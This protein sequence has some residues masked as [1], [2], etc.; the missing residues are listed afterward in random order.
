MKCLPGHST[1]VL[2]LLLLL[3]MLFLV[4]FGIL[5]FRVEFL[6]GVEQLRQELKFIPSI[7][8]LRSRILVREDKNVV[9]GTGYLQANPSSYSL[10]ETMKNEPKLNTLSC[11]VSCVCTCDILGL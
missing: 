10:T 8:T 11:P 5:L 4:G 9:G 6:R 7:Q 1:V 2:N 3:Y